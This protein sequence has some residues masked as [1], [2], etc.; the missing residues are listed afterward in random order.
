MSPV[1][2]KSNTLSHPS[3][4]VQKWVYIPIPSLSTYVLL[5]TL[6]ALSLFHHVCV[7]IPIPQEKLISGKVY[8]CSL[9]LIIIVYVFVSVFLFL[10][11]LFIRRS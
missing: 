4:G 5:D 8:E 10:L 7:I 1:L 3:H 11:L 9:K 2:K 6:T